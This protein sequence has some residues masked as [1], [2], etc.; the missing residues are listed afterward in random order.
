MTRTSSSIGEENVSRI[1]DL[2]KFQSSPIWNFSATCPLCLGIVC[3]HITPSDKWH[4]YGVEKNPYYYHS[5]THALGLH[6]FHGIKAQT[7][8]KTEYVN[9]IRY[10]TK[11]T[12][13]KFG[14]M[15]TMTKWHGG[16]NPMFVSCTSTSQAPLPNYP[17]TQTPCPLTYRHVK[18]HSFAKVAKF[19]THT[20][21][22]HHSQQHHA[23]KPKNNMRG[24]NT[25]QVTWKHHLSTLLVG[26]TSGVHS[27]Q[28]HLHT[29]TIKFTYNPYAHMPICNHTI[30]IN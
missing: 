11:T 7:C 24:E 5:K 28:T 21:T 10:P 30:N 29:Y 22:P 6:L 9:S 14:F 19:H 15:C 2:V 18:V 25:K 20:Y 23:L 1:P 26:T 12:T 3:T 8:N 17:H 13:T 16:L 27:L 4:H